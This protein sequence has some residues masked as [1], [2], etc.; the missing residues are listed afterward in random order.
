[1]IFVKIVAA[2]SQTYVKILK[3]LMPQI[4]KQ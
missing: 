1:M 3:Q 4:N 2:I